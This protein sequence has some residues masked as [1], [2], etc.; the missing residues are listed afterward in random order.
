MRC[1]A[2]NASWFVH[3]RRKCANGK[4]SPPSMRNT[5]AMCRLLGCVAR[6]PV[7]LRHELLDAA[8]SLIREAG[9]NDSGWGM[10]VYPRGE[11]DAPRCARFPENAAA[12]GGFEAAA[13]LRGRIV[14]AHVRKATVGG[15]S[16]ANTQ[17]FCLGEYA[18]CHNGTLARPE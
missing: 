2:S 15:L 14:M 13:D 9:E 4:S 1:R 3:E 7:S 10:A 18:F 12:S 17:P 16:E 6:D 5:C 11:G 8:D